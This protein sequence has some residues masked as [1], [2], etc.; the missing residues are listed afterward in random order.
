MWKDE[1]GFWNTLMNK[2]ATTK[3]VAM[4][5][6]CALFLY[7]G[8]FAFILLLKRREKETLPLL[9]NQHHYWIGTSENTTNG[10]CRS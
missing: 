7:G 5:A 9:R 1:N 6:V 3:Q 8:F 10:I 2:I 4:V